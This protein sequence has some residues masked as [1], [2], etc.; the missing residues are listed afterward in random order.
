[1]ALERGQRGSQGLSFY[2]ADDF[3]AVGD[4]VIRSSEGDFLGFGC[5]VGVAIE[6]F[7]RFPQK[8]TE[9]VPIGEFVSRVGLSFFTF[10]DLADI[11]RR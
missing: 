9:E 7:C 11:C 8:R 6:K 2:I 4:F 3:Q 10:A 1:M 5:K